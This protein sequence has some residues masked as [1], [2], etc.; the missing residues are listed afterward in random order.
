M[1]RTSALW[2]KVHAEF[3]ALERVQTMSVAMMCEHLGIIPLVLLTYPDRD[4]VKEELQAQ[5]A[6]LLVKVVKKR[7]LDFYENQKPCSRSEIFE[8]LVAVSSV[9]GFLCNHLITPE[10]AAEIAEEMVPE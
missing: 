6:D 4:L 9:Q 10:V 1:D 5:I 7:V 3:V 2:D 8:R